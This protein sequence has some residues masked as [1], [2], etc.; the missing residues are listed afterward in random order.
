VDLNTATEQ[1]LD[2]LPGI[3]PAS[4]KKIIAG[5]PYF[6]VGEL[7]TVGVPNKTIKKITP[8]VAVGPAAVRAETKNS[9][10]RK[11][12]SSPNAA[13]SK[14]GNKNAT[15]P[16]ATQAE[17][18]GDGR[19]WVNAKAGFYH[20]EG[21]K[22]YG[23]TKQGKYTTEAEAIKAGYRADKEKQVTSAVLKTHR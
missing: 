19:V 14:S 5:W 6:S 11:S 16:P 8:I 12:P 18:G 21:D 2:D 4:A 3:G 10:A 1:D 7:S 13:P 15:S 22:W 23:K 17:G 9:T 20:K